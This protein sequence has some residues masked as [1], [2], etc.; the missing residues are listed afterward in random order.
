[1][2]DIVQ[3]KRRAQVTIPKKARVA[4][5]IEEGDYLEL[6]VAPEALV[7][8]KRSD[9]KATSRSVSAESLKKLSGVIS[10]GGN[11]LKESEEIHD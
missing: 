9:N 1:M 10:V 6:E 2:V 7:F 4:L 8:H 3:V 5:G 11:G